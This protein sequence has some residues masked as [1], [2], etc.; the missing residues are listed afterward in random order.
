MKNQYKVLAEK[1]S[2]IATESYG[3]TETKI[4]E[5][6]QKMNSARDFQSFL[7]LFKELPYQNNTINGEPVSIIIKRII[8]DKIGKLRPYLSAYEIR[9]YENATPQEYFF[10]SVK[11]LM[12][13]SY[14]ETRYGKTNASWQSAATKEV[15]NYAK[16]FFNKWL[17]FKLV[18]DELYKN[19]PGVNIDI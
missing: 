15:L 13:L 16:K 2:F 14:L 11:E 4:E 1:Y 8:N 7:D 3:D 5:I 9:Y 10:A 19:N 6:L 17:S 12:K 18:Q